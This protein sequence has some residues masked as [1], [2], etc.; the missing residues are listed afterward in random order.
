MRRIVSTAG[1][2][3]LLLL[4]SVTGLPAL[5][6]QGRDNCTGY[7]D[8]VPA[9]VTTGGIWCLR[10]NL[11]TST[12]S[13]GVLMFTGN[14]VTLDCNGYRIE[15]TDVSN[16]AQALVLTGNNSVVRHCDIR[17]F[18]R[19]VSVSGSGGLVEDNRFL[20]TGYLPIY[21]QSA[22]GIIRR[23][24][25][26]GVGNHDSNNGAVTAVVAY[27]SG[28]VID[29]VID[30][31]TPRANASGNASPTALYLY[32][33]SGQVSGNRIRNLVPLGTGAAVGI[34]SWGGYPYMSR[35]HIVG[36]GLNRAGDYSIRCGGGSEQFAGENILSGF[37]HST[38]GSFTGSVVGCYAFRGPIVDKL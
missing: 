31:V 17:S 9:N 14:N 12:P 18:Y 22:G 37:A 15:H 8:A 28:D 7:I 38:S 10:K 33:V 24:H 5:A 20:Q 6:G 34:E 25:V 36:P 29:N 4:S 3:G 2:L 1:I 30:T 16:N 35:N 32:I 23:N 27:G 26:F 13:G 19:G 11:T 21:V